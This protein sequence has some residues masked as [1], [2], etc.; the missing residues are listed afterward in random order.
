M[1]GLAKNLKQQK[2]DLNE[3]FDDVLSELRKWNIESVA[4]EAGLS[5]ST[6]YFWLSGQ[7][8]NPGKNNLINVAYVI[9]YKFALVGLDGKPKAKSK[10]PA[11]RVVK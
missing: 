9:G 11:L 6:L 4:E 7:T 1:T 3:A 2:E 5:P 10:K 8:K